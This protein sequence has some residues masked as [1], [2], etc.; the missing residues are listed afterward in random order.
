[1]Y[2]LFTQHLNRFQIGVRLNLVWPNHIHYVFTESGFQSALGAFTTAA[3]NR[4]EI[5]LKPV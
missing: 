4:F 1:M 3:L 5:T 2:S